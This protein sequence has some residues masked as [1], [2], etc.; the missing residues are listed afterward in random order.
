MA[1]DC[2][3]LVL[4]HRLLDDGLRTAHL[5]QRDRSVTVDVWMS[6]GR[7]FIVEA[8]HRDLNGLYVLGLILELLAQRQGEE[9]FRGLRDEAPGD[10]FDEDV[11]VGVRLDQV[12]HAQCRQ[13]TRHAEADEANYDHVSFCG[14]PRAP[15]S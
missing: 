4:H 10:A 13:D 5:R 12:G 15:G 8:V 11:D 7:R 9:R 6:A 1:D 14:A 3:R 2:V